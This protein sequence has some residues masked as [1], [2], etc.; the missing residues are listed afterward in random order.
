MREHRHDEPIVFERF[1]VQTHGDERWNN[2]ARRHIVL[3]WWKS[4][5]GHWR[6]GAPAIVESVMEKVKVKS[7][8]VGT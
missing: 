6:G 1:V 7:V 4:S 5:L 2:R 8:K 3:R